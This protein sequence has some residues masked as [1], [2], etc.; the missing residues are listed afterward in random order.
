MEFETKYFAVQGEFKFTGTVSVRNILL[1]LG[2]SFQ[3]SHGGVRHD[4]MAFAHLWHVYE[5]PNSCYDYFSIFFS[6]QP[7]KKSR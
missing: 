7:N 3:K 2:F 6:S 5:Y 4:L 1:L